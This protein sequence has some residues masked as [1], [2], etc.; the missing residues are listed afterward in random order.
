MDVGGYVQGFI[1][2]YGKEVVGRIAK[3]V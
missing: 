1:D 2:R 3:L